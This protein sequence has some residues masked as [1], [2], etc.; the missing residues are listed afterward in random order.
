MTPKRRRMW[1]RR[2]I[3]S[4]FPATAAMLW[5]RKASENWTDTSAASWPKSLR[6]RRWKFAMITPT[7]TWGAPTDAWRCEQDSSGESTNILRR[8]APRRLTSR[9]VGSLWTL[10]LVSPDGLVQHAQMAGEP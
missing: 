10:A 4:P 5:Q 7:M 6:R 8:D 3:C 9:P 2:Q 1:R